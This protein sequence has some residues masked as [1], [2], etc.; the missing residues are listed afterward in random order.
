V[1]QPD[2][3]R[4]QL[5]AA[6]AAMAALPRAAGALGMGSQFDV[7]QI[8]VPGTLA[9]EAA[10][11]RLLFEVGQGTSVEV[12]SEVVSVDPEDPA[13][14]EHPFSV[15]VGEGALPTFSDEAV[16]QL[17]RYLSYGGFLL[18][19]DASGSPSGAFAQ[20]VRDLAGRLFPTR[21]L[22]PL[23]ADHSIYRSFF[24]LDRPVGRVDAAPF[25][26][27]ITLGPITPLVFCPND[28]SGA[29]DRGPD[30]RNLYP[31]IPGGE[32]QRTEALKLG[33]NL[34]MYSLVSNYKHDTAHVLE[35]MREGR[36]E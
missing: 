30:G 11:K 23:P 20:S 10:W 8:R 7:A 25:L 15:L 21:P 6:A 5:L 36:I 12:S 14:F 16:A 24:L 26:E 22:S 13:L 18:I 4:R 1:K 35:L 19:D 33:I 9:R 32:R 27:G 17:A 2:W 3:S 29:L 28:L 34:V 31:V